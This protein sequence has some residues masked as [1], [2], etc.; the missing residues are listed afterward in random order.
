LPLAADRE[1]PVSTNA[2]VAFFALDPEWHMDLHS[3]PGKLHRCSLQPPVELSECAVHESGRCNR[4]HRDRPA[5]RHHGGI[6]TLPLPLGA[7]DCLGFLGWTLAFHVIPVITMVGPW[8]LA[9]KELRLYDT[10]PALILTHVA[11]NL[12][13]AVWLMMSF[14]K[15]L[16]P[17]VEE[18]AL[19]D[20]CHP[21]SAFWHVTLPLVLPGLIATGVL[22]FIFSWN[23]F[24]IALNLT[25]QVNATVPVVVS[26][27][28]ND[29]EVLHSP[30]AA[31][32]IPA[33][34]AALLLM[35][36][37]QRYIVQGLTLGSVK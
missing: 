27:F 1:R 7:L 9:F 20:G 19:V 15:A 21:M 18:P 23:E 36:L 32:S 10:R 17:E 34:L 5:D 6:F 11:M 24:A 2:N 30:V 16:P 3:N 13:M 14:F 37:G 31:A 4:Q 29:Y 8:Y 35:F 22:S 26:K 12:P 33:T 28:A 25:S